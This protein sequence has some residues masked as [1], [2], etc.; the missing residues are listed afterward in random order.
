[1]LYYM[2]IISNISLLLSANNGILVEMYEEEHTM[3]II[4]PIKMMSYFLCQPRFSYYN[5][6]L[7]LI[8]VYLDHRKIILFPCTCSAMVAWRHSQSASNMHQ[9]NSIQFDLIYKS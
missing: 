5:K 1:M 9:T 7:E 6:F 2:Q 8:V 4:I 3:C